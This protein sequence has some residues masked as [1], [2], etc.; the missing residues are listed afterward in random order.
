MSDS[1]YI[2][3][4][5]L[6]QWK[7]W[8]SASKET[9]VDGCGSDCP[10]KGQRRPHRCQSP[11]FLFQILQLFTWWDLHALPSNPRNQQDPKDSVLVLSAWLIK[12]FLT[13]HVVTLKIEI[14]IFSEKAFVF[15]FHP[16]LKS[17]S[18]PTTTIS[19][20]C[21][22]SKVFLSAPCQTVA[23]KTFCLR[24]VRSATK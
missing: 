11:F 14:H 13:E 3:F 19:S 7:L 8:S 1:E 4:F 20:V 10:E 24:H 16:P 12:A 6:H 9:A 21:S 2:I 17:N 18:G 23:L 15:W 5:F 22:D